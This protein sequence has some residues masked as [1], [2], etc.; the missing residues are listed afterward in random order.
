M[1]IRQQWQRRRE[2]NSMMISLLLSLLLF[3]LLVNKNCSRIRATNI[4]PPQLIKNPKC[5]IQP[6]LVSYVMRRGLE[7]LLVAFS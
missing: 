1:I 4:L 2:M 7:E 3:P 6:Y 5:T